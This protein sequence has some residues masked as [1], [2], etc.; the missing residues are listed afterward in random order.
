MQDVLVEWLSELV[1]KQMPQILP[2]SDPSS[3]ICVLAGS[4]IIQRSKCLAHS[5]AEIV[6]RDL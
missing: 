2:A 1:K 5:G 6:I 4:L 3:S